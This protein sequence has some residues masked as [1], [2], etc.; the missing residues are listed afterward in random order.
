M[1]GIDRSKVASM[2]YNIYK[3]NGKGIGYSEEKSKEYTLKS[4][5]DCIKDELKSTFVPEGTVAVTAVQSEPEASGSK[6]KITSKPENLKSK[7]MTKPD[8][9]TAKIKI[10]KR[11]EPVPQSLIKP[12]PRILK[13][14]DQKNRI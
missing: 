2:I 3:N 6:A 13:S 4:Y 12:K 8:P 10:L 5:C 14:K 11:S 1:A 9:K 7:V